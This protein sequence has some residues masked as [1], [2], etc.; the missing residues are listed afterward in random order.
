M[1]RVTDLSSP[2]EVGRYYLVP[3]VAGKVFE[4]W[5]NWPVVGRLHEDSQYI[6]FP[7]QH[8]HLDP[9]FLSAREAKVTGGPFLMFGA[10]LQQNED[11]NE[12]LTS[13][14]VIFRRRQ[15]HR[16][17]PPHPCQDDT[18]ESMT[19][20]PVWWLPSLEDAYQDAQLKPGLVCPHRGA[21]LASMPVDDDGCVT[22]PLHGLRWHVE[23]GRLVKKTKRAE[24]A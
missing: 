22:C 6:S 9:R 20:K 5:S 14:R 7:W 23:S 13:A 12:H 21:S 4:L 18:Y 2:P 24:A 1:K 11:F 8:Y 10:P 19:G 3:T 15:C 16:P 17:M